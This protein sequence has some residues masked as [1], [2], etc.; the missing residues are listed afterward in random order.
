MHHHVNMCNYYLCHIIFTA[1]EELYQEST[2]LQSYVARTWQH[3]NGHDTWIRGK[4]LKIHM[5]P[6]SDTFRTRHDSMIEVSVLYSFKDRRIRVGRDNYIIGGF[7]H[8]QRLFLSKLKSCFTDSFLN[9]IINEEYFIKFVYITKQKIPAI[10]Y[11][12]KKQ[13]PAIVL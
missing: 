4:F 5:I 2:I 13:I 9:H 7:V 8:P 1:W 11:I 3:W 6:V 10:L 12:T